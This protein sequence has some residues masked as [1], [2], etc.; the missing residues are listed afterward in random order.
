MR[1]ANLLDVDNIMEVF[2]S[3][4][5]QLCAKDYPA[6]IIEPWA[7][8]HT[9][10]A[11]EQAINKQQIWVAEDGGEILGYLNVVS[12]EILS[13]FIAAEHAGKGVGKALAKLGI[14]LAQENH[15]GAIYL[16][17]TLTAEPFYQKLGFAKTAEGFFSH[18][19]DDLDIAVVKME[20]RVQE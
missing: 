16:E 12:G 11:F 9:P 1:L 10:S 8:N 5:T 3:S 7:N 20:Y 17:S 2:K 19:T 18:G 14:K 15:Q 6:S 4:V 13:L